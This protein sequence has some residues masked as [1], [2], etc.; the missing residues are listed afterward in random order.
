MQTILSSIF[1]SHAPAK[2][3]LIFNVW[4]VKRSTNIITKTTSAIAAAAVKLKAVIKI[5][6]AATG[7]TAKQRVFNSFVK[8][9]FPVSVIMCGGSFNGRIKIS[10]PTRK[11]SGVTHAKCSSR[12]LKGIAAM[13]HAISMPGIIGLENSKI[14][15]N[16]KLILALCSAVRFK[17][18]AVISTIGA[19]KRAPP[20]EGRSPKNAGIMA[21]VR[22]GLLSR[23]CSERTRSSKMPPVR[24]SISRCSKR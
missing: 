7:A 6:L 15:R 20:S 17:P 11:N 12:L 19:E 2:T 13:L 24:S 9:T 16:Q 5:K 3:S 1:L 22:R 4:L 21:R 18:L 14:W 8:F 10:Q 23:R